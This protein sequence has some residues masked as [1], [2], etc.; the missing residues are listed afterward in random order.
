ME[1]IWGNVGYWE[2]EDMVAARNWLVAQGVARPEA[3]L[4][5]GESYG[6]FLTLWGLGKRP[7]LWAGG[8]GV[9]AGAEWV[10]GYEDSSDALKGAIRCWFGGTPEE[11][12]AE[13][14][15]SS[16]ITYAAEVRAPVLVFQGRN[17]TRSPAREIEL[18]E[19]RMKELGKE[20]EVVWFDSGHMSEGPEQELAFMER[21]IEFARRVAAKG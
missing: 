7:D 9:V 20:I 4:L 5:Y 10:A 17:D 12:P 21:M 14:A 15:A 11:K 2:L 13:Y 3:I 8:I 18:Y 19:A 6:G 16:P 1:K